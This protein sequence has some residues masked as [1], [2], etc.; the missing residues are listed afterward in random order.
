MGDGPRYFGEIQVIDSSEFHHFSHVYDQIREPLLEFPNGVEIDNQFVIRDSVKSRDVKRY[1]ESHGE[2]LP[3]AQNRIGRVLG[4][5]EEMGV[6]ES[7][8]ADAYSLRDF[9]EE[10]DAAVQDAIRYR[11]IVFDKNGFPEYEP[12]EVL[13]KYGE[14]GW[15]A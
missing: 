13:E 15:D 3:P 10:D 4:Y 1:L 11:T 6:L 5:L 12:E 8:S 14:P 9:D 2:G 7:C